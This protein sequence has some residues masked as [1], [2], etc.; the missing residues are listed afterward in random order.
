MKCNVNSSLE[1]EFLCSTELTILNNFQYYGG[2]C[3]AIEGSEVSKLRS[4][5]KMPLMPTSQSAGRLAMPSINAYAHHSH[6]MHNSSSCHSPSGMTQSLSN[7]Q[8]FFSNNQQ[9][10]LLPRNHSTSNSN[11]V[12]CGHGYP[13]CGPTTQTMYTNAAN[14][15][16]TIWLQ[17]Q[18]FQQNLLRNTQTPNIIQKPGVQCFQKSPG[19]SGIYRTVGSGQNSLVCPHKG[20]VICRSEP[21]TPVGPPQH[22]QQMEWKVIRL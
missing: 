20:P 13:S 11:S 3:G 5:R 18:L 6:T 4:S 19:C 2:C 10:N 14:L 1:Y 9:S 16:Q 22:G 8:V 12:T 15:Q 17:Q 7:N 21:T